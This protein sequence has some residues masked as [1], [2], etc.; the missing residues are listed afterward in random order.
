MLL[1]EKSEQDYFVIP[2]NFKGNL[3][4]TVFWDVA[5]CSHVE[6]DRRYKGAYFLHLQGDVMM[7]AVCTSE[8]SGQLQRDYT[9][10]HPRRLNFILAAV[11]T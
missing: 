8:M 2:F 6:V 1:K 3:K 7:E 4:F 11:R 9:A 5:P 10:L